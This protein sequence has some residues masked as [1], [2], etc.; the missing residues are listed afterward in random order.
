MKD[1]KKTKKQLIDEL[2]E[3]R[4]RKDTFQDITEQNRAEEALRKSEERSDALF[5]ISNRLASVHNTDEILDLIVN[6]SA[7]LLGANAAYMRLLEGDGLVASAATES[8]IEFLAELAVARPTNKVE[9]GESL[10]GHVMATKEPLVIDDGANQDVVSQDTSH[11][12]Q[13][14]EMHGTAAVPLISNENPIGVLVVVDTRVRRFTEDEVSLLTAFADQAALALD[15]A[16]LLSEAE[17]RERQAAQLYE[18]T[19]N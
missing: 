11:I 1:E 17:A 10:T 7:R 12:R 6:E 2:A 5:Q 19:T 4:G 16:R 15:K 13:K 9:E 14:Y 18:V 3:L 8:A